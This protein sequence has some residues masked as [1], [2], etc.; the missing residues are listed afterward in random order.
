[1]LWLA[2]EHDPYVLQSTETLGRVGVDF[3]ELTKSKL[4][5]R[6]PQFGADDI[7][8][9]MLERGSGA[10]MAR[11][12]VQAVARVAVTE[13]VAFLQTSVLE[14]GNDFTVADGRA[15]AADQFVFACGPWL[16][17]IFPD[18]LSQRITPSRQEV[19]FFGA[20]NSAAYSSPELPIWIDFTCEAYGFPDL[21]GRGVKVAIDRHGEAFDAD[22]G[23]RIAS[24]AGLSEVR[25]YL[26]RRLPSLSSAPVVETRVCQYENTSNGDFLID[27]HP[28]RS[29]VWLVGGGSGHGFKHGPSVAEYVVKRIEGKTENIEPRFSLLSKQTNQHRAVY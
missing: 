13:G 27:R 17:K 7:E 3:E 22:S 25:T 8:W 6:Y 5:Q 20:Q 9:A 2:H 18:L 16:I 21:E 4:Q 10:L 15:I 23:D 1:V 24:A 28:D 11:R 26:Q 29:N 19:F 12:A 14:C